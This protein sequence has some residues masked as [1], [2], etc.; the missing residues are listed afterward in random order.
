MRLQGYC[1]ECHQ[2]KWVRVPPS[3]LWKIQMMGKAEGI[4]TDC[5]E[6]R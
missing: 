6:K 4:C 3:M 1:T 5:E 2:Y